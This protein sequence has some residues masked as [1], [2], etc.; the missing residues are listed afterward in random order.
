MKKNKKRRFG[1]LGLL[2]LALVITATTT[3]TALGFFENYAV[4][5]GNKLQIVIKQ[6]K[7]SST[8]T[9]KYATGGWYLFPERIEA[10]RSDTAPNY[11][12][13]AINASF[14]SK[15]GLALTSAEQETD[16]D[17]PV[18]RYD[19]FTY[20]ASVVLSKVKSWVDAGY[21]T[22]EDLKK[23]ITLQASRAINI[24]K[25]GTKIGTV[26]SYPE[27][28]EFSEKNHINWGAN[29]WTTFY[30]SYDIP[31]YVPLQWVPFSIQVVDE[32]GD[33]IIAQYDSDFAEFPHGEI[34]YGEN[35][36]NL[37]YPGTIKG[38]TYDGYKIM[39]GGST[40]ASGA[41]QTVNFTANYSQ[42][43]GNDVELVFMYAKNPDPTTP[44]FIS[45]GGTPEITDPPTPAPPPP[46]AA[47]PQAYDINQSYIRYYSTDAGNW[48][49][50]YAGSTSDK[51]ASFGGVDG[52]GSLSSI[53]KRTS[54]YLI[55][56]DASGNKW[57]FAADGTNA[58]YVHP[59]TYNGY[60][61]ESADVKYITEL[62]FPSTIT[63]NGTTY[64]VTHIGGGTDKYATDD[65]NYTG[66]GYLYKSYSYSKYYSEDYY[67]YAQDTG[68][69][70]I[71]KYHYV[72]MKYGILGNGELTSNACDNTV[73]YSNGEITS[74]QMKNYNNSYIFYNTT[75][76]SVTIPSTVK[77]IE[78]YA[79]QY[80]QALET[81]K[82]GDGITDIKF[83]A[84]L[85]DDKPTLS[86]STTWTD[87]GNQ[88]YIYY[89]Y[90]GDYSLS[91]P[92]SVMKAWQTAS[93]LTPAM[94]FPY[95]K[96]LKNI[97]SLAFA[98]HYNLTDV[99]LPATI[100]TIGEDAFLDCK[101]DNIRIPN[102][103]CSIFDAAGSTEYYTTLGSKGRV[104]NPT[105][106]HTVPDSTAMSYGLKYDGYYR[107]YCGYPVTYYPNGGTPNSPIEI[108]SALNINYLE[109]ATPVKYAN[110]TQSSSDSYS[111][112]T[113]SSYQYASYLDED[114]TLYRL[115]LL[116]SRASVVSPGTTFTE[117]IPVSNSYA[118]GVSHYAWDSSGN[119]WFSGQYSWRAVDSSDEWYSK[120]SGM[121]DWRKVTIP[122]NT[123]DVQLDERGVFALDSSGYVYFITPYNSTTR[124][125]NK[126]GDILFKKF[127]VS[128]YNGS[129]D[130]D[131]DSML[132]GITTDNRFVYS[133]E[134]GYYGFC[135]ETYSWSS[136][137]VLTADDFTENT[138]MT[139]AFN[140]QEIADIKLV[141]NSIMV[142]ILETGD[143][144][145]WNN[146]TAYS[147]S[148]NT[149]TGYNIVDLKYLGVSYY[150]NGYTYYACVMTDASGGKY[151]GIVYTSGSSA[152]CVMHTLG[153]GVEIL[154]AFDF[155]PLYGNSWATDDWNDTSSYAG[156]TL[157][158]SDG[159][160][161]RYKASSY[162]DGAVKY[163]SVKFKKI[164]YN[165]NNLY[166]LAED[167]TL[168]SAGNNLYGQLGTSS[169][170]DYE[171]PSQSDAMTLR[172]T[173]TMTYEDIYFGSGYW[174]IALGTDGNVYYAGEKP[175]TTYGGSYS[176]QKKYAFTALGSD[177]TWPTSS[178]GTARRYIKGYDYDTEITTGK[179]FAPPSGKEFVSW[180][181]AAGGT[182]TTYHPGDKVEL[183]AAL[184]LY[185]Q[186]ST[187]EPVYTII[188]YDRNGG[189]GTMANT[190]KPYDTTSITL[191]AN[192]FARDGYTFNGW[193]TK[194]DGT[195]TAY[196]NQG[197]ITVSKGSI[198]T[199]YAQW[200]KV[201]PISYTL[202]YMTYP[203][204]TANNTAWKTKT[205]VYDAVETVEGQPYTP[206]SG[207][208]VTYNLNKPS[209]MSTT[210]TPLSKT[211][212][213]IAA[214]TFNKWRLYK[215]NSGGNQYY[216]GSQYSK[217]DTI[218]KLTQKSGEVIYLY[219]TWNA[220]G[221]Y[222]LLPYSE[223][224]GYVLNGWSESKDGSSET[225]PVYS[226]EDAENVGIFTPS[227]NTVL[228]GIWTPLTYDITLDGQGA[229]T[230]TQT[231]VTMTFDAVCPSV[232]P[233]S[234]T[235]YIF[236]G[237]FTGTEGTGTQYYDKDGNGLLKW[238][239]SDGTVTT[240]YA[241]WV[242]DKAVSYDA[243]GGTGTMGTSWVDSD[244]DYLDLPANA[245]TAPTGY[246]FAYWC[247]TAAGCT[248]ESAS[249]HKHWADKGRVTG[250]TGRITLYA[251]WAPNNYTVT[252]NYNG[253]TKGS[254]D[255]SPYT[256]TYKTNSY[257][258]ISWGLPTREGYDFLGFYTSTSGGAQVYNASGG[259]VEGTYWKDGKWNYLGDVTLYARWTAK[260]YNVAL[261]NDGG[262]PSPAP[263]VTPKYDS[264][265]PAV[266][267]PT[268]KYTVTFNANTGTCAT[269]SLTSTYIF[270]GYYS[271]KNGTGTQYYK[272]DGTS[273]RTWNIAQN[274]TLYAKWTS[275]AVTLPT[276]SK[277]GYTFNGWYTAASG[278]TLVDVAGK[279]YTPSA[280][281]T[282][283][284]QWTANTYTVTL[285]P[286]GGTPTPAPTVKPTYDA[287]MPS[288]TVPTR[289]YTVTFNANTGT[290][291]TTSLVSEYTFGGYFSGK[292]GTGTQYYK[293]DGTSARAWD[294]AQNT[295]LYA[296]WTSKAVTLPT[297]TK[298]GYTFQ[299]W[300]TAA[301]GG[302]KIGVAGASYTPTADI[303]LYAQ[304]KANELDIALNDR[305]ATS[306]NH[307]KTVH[308]VYDEKGKDIILPTKTGYTFQGYYTGIRGSGKKYYDRAGICITEWKEENITELFA[309]WIQDEILIPEEDDITEPTPLPE[310]DMEGSVGRSDTKGLLYADD[311][312][313]STGALNDL[314]PYLV[315]DTDASKGVI[316][317]TEKL[318]FRAKMGEWIFHYKLHRN[319]GTDYV[320][321]YVTVPYRT[322]YERTEDE[323]LVISA[324]QNK[325]YTFL[326]PKVW[327]YWEIIESG[328][329]YPEK[330]T[331]TNQ[332]IKNYFAVIPVKRERNL[333]GAVPAYDVKQYGDKT[334][335]VFWD[336]HDAD[337]YPVLDITLT[338]EQ[339]IISDVPDTL[340]DIDAVLEVICRNAA[341]A[342]TRQPRVRSDRFLL[343][344]NV[345]L[346][347][348]FEDNG[349]GAGLRSDALERF[350]NSGKI[351][352]TSYIQSY[353]S[354]IELDEE[355]PNG[356]YKTSAMITYTGDG[357]NINTPENV[358]VELTDMNPIR[359]HTP[360]VCLG[361]IDDGPEITETG[362][363]LTL[364]DAMNFFTVSVDNAGT[365]RMSFGYGTKDYAFALSGKSNMA[366]Q[367]GVCLNQVQFPFE[368]Y[369][370]VGNDSKQ[371]DGSVIPDGDFLLT[372][373][374]WFTV[375]TR[376]Q[377]FYV[378][379]TMKNGKYQIKFRSVAANCPKDN[380]GQFV[381]G[382][383]EYHAN[384]S[385]SCY[386]AADVIEVEVRSYLRDFKITSAND[387]LAAEQLENGCQALTLKKG[388]GF[389]FELLTQGEF[390]GDGAAIN[391]VPSFFWESEDGT[392]RREVKLYHTGKLP[393]DISKL[394]YAWKEE[395]ILRR[396]ENYDVILQRFLGTG[397]IP[398]D[399]LCVAK[400][401]PLEEYAKKNTF[402]GR[403][404]FFF[405]TGYLIIHF[406]ISVKSNEGV[407]Y[408]YNKW[409]ETKLFED[410]TKGGWGYI[411]GDIIRYDLSKSIA[412]D[413][414][415]GGSE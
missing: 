76:K 326:L 152:N 329:Y 186:W 198:T 63:Y 31:L 392:N 231:D 252:L 240:L 167:G 285:E 270:G 101:L 375:G 218:S 91:S 54:S 404:D 57:Y 67:S 60:L 371:S 360:V 40:I 309:Y 176:D 322:Q 296:K 226:P 358:T 105:A 281:I 107:L 72:K 384:I 187:A 2:V 330:I 42:I 261:D 366:R 311:Y 379:V 313:D 173:G 283:Y 337:G 22:R 266:T 222:V 160:V 5:D 114:G 301:S 235:R 185:A 116:N 11:S 139:S 75:L 398:A 131:C 18:F 304:W 228:Y 90:N 341:R 56:T 83:S 287:N 260:T 278:G 165:Y 189:T 383:E 399:I 1:K 21:F 289:K 394:C 87:A 364:K 20:P 26:Y 30:T 127:Y 265:M 353:L 159:Y 357:S 324:R 104:E 179:I 410:A 151:I 393:K 328:M 253:G 405:R 13:A 263:T 15:Y 246:H 84:F 247:Q 99:D 397:F 88:C 291:A 355:K 303:T 212:D 332:A 138:G 223:A 112:G 268:R 271:G 103:T 51:V 109:G 163:A 102:T 362:Y 85:V 180:N 41:G 157:W 325:T 295:T 225:Y 350:A 267:P 242:P 46:T 69:M 310:Q 8:A 78:M 321:F 306:T 315:Y 286:E 409:Q 188:R 68:S 171:Y 98:Y 288:V 385:P 234:R 197:S 277:T 120:Y 19:T 208:T 175:T 106:I 125:F 200:K 64:T 36:T 168:W 259:C 220:A 50:K 177:Y 305:G 29:S 136:R 82:G 17:D 376:K 93:I 352:E 372:E 290:C 132:A 205:L 154:D 92:T 34:F 262:K 245:F 230:H 24:L 155:S 117:L 248:G 209:G 275:V 373:G 190:V 73:Y 274:T 334:A 312:E 141:G 232:T 387:P 356:E 276:A 255:T 396:H 292:D 363:V 118:S 181:T 143:M 9:V 124:Q 162:A 217:G 336:K 308:M 35:I 206:A 219:P 377:Q 14:Y 52:N 327:D 81:I 3:V 256:V 27:M 369:V 368:V 156:I 407:V 343:D 182:G 137:Y 94:N 361:K 153:A 257:N 202:I 340:P 196:P 365:H 382:E 130:Y 194:A 320:R 346:S 172:K 211:S 146:S 244:K 115:D 269:A 164:V 258:D 12:G 174:I 25:N 142:F 23:G 74:S 62:V 192:K 229:T 403:E 236:M 243:N 123:V 71:N 150:Q 411:P 319:T 273:A 53:T 129:T 250:I 215:V 221:S 351:A 59:H 264:A 391:I 149:K 28:E 380:T 302:T 299:G 108:Y 119:L 38:Y 316:P 203:F 307:T 207:Y 178:T 16:S 128:T 44:P 280:D 318:S 345:I 413:Y 347:D 374:T 170:Y 414:E 43:G 33:A 58:T 95:M 216:A 66:A 111:W 191:D 359:I 354:G 293:A 227:K 300:Y 254:G 406:D 86:S 294:I 70:N 49:G 314:Q 238:Q 147:S 77:T 122:A 348:E 10:A 133:R 272:A 4:L 378:P 370:D 279:S 135:L 37:G 79:F 158:T 113:Y 412:E 282:L 89:Y 317:G 48:L 400:E 386:V 166:G 349:T 169:S 6:S 333:S 213:T 241:H 144:I 237:Y 145:L 210:P 284:A 134:D 126:N 339:Y 323:K 80:C 45:P 97:A 184:S 224:D 55:G 395:P 335:H 214:S 298:T 344:G 342:D 249:G 161:T 415:I 39:A 65:S 408:N 100:T 110:Y 239:I 199:L 388:Y 121:Y 201:T 338:D 390:Y 96:S 7:A 193:N 402:S 251:Q 204:G 61:A 389:S 331:V 32:N 195:G 367:E 297:P 381:F 401:F 47:P 140:G 148:Y 233:P 183:S